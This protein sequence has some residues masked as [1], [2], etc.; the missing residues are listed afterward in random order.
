MR[1]ERPKCFLPVISLYSI[2]RRLGAEVPK[3]IAPLLS[4]G[5]QAQTCRALWFLHREM[6]R[7]N[8]LQAVMP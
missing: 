3:V 2:G 4:G 5:I 8:Q 1:V 7:A 6:P